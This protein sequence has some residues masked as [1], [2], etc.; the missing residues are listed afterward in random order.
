MRSAGQARRFR[1]VRS[2]PRWLRLR[3]SRLRSRVRFSRRS[4]RRLATMVSCGAAQLRRR[5]PKS[6][7]IG[8]NSTTFRRERS[9]SGRCSLA[10]GTAP[11]GQT[12]MDPARPRTMARTQRVASV[13]SS[14]SIVRRM[15]RAGMHRT[16]AAQ[17]GSSGAGW[18]CTRAAARVR[19]QARGSRSWIQTTFEE[20]PHFALRSSRTRRRSSRTRSPKTKL[21]PLAEGCLPQPHV[22]RWRIRIRSQTGHPPRSQRRR[23]GAGIGERPMMQRTRNLNRGKRRRSSCAVPSD[24]CSAGVAAT[25]PGSSTRSARTLLPSKSIRWHCF[26]SSTI[27]RRNRKPSSPRCSAAA[28]AT[29]KMMLMT[30]TTIQQKKHGL[31]GC[32]GG[33][34]IA[35]LS[36]RRLRVRRW[37]PRATSRTS[38]PKFVGFRCS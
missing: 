12:Q 28:P 7:P 23:G 1:C 16:K 2:R 13:A 3:A 35:S 14:S 33:P 34:R 19:G 5:P 10:A 38:R 15:T 9:R 18:T 8:S 11:P 37:M 32:A 36:R 22:R 21:Q 30:A 26:T 31:G 20:P 6:L 25:M 24:R 4:S 27:I 17:N 29:L